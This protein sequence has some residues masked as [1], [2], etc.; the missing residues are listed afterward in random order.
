[1]SSASLPQAQLHAPSQA[2]ES[3]HLVLIALSSARTHLSPLH[4]AGFI[5]VG[6][7]ALGGNPIAGRL[8]A[9]NNNNFNAPITFAVRLISL[10]L[11]SVFRLESLSSSA[12]SL[13]NLALD[14]SKLKADLISIPTGCHARC[15]LC[16]HVLRP[17]SPGEGKG[18]VEGLGVSGEELSA[19][20]E[21]RA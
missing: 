21:S 9:N 4:F 1:M 6:L 5:I 2:T 7:A 16:L 18:H 14:K 3:E 11:L 12:P 15:R 8:L 13:P 20:D 19:E 17:S 10:V